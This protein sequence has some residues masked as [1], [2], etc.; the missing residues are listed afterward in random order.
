MKLYTDDFYR[1]KIKDI[2]EEIVESLNTYLEN[3]DKT[4]I[5]IVRYRGRFKSLAEEYIIDNYKDYFYQKG[6]QLR[7]FQALDDRCKN[8]DLVFYTKKT[9][10]RFKI[11]IN[12]N[13]TKDMH[14]KNVKFLEA[15]YYIHYSEYGQIEDSHI[16][17]KTIGYVIN[18]LDKSYSEEHTELLNSY[19]TLANQYNCHIPYDEFQELFIAYRK[20]MNICY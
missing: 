2:A 16:E 14:F 5:G 20:L 8:I 15:I 7:V 13:L 19:Q 12:I 6:L 1:K 18:S 9:L 10:R 4:G 11:R 3:V 17:N